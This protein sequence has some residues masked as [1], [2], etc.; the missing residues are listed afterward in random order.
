MSPAAHAATGKS[1]PHAGQPSAQLTPSTITR[2]QIS[3]KWP[4]HQVQSLLEGSPRRQR[5]GNRTVGSLKSPA[6]Q[7]PPCAWWLRAG[8]EPAGQGLA[9][10]GR[11]GAQLSLQLVETKFSSKRNKPLFLPQSVSLWCLCQDCKNLKQFSQL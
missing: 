3:W 10:W 5:A 1:R 8:E 6:G 9:S 7:I 4:H 11:R 2:S